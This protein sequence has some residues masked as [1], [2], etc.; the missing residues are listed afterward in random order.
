M[1]S[2]HMCAQL[3]SP[4]KDRTIPRAFRIFQYLYSSFPRFRSKGE[5]KETRIRRDP[6]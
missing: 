5:T 2:A 6:I 4:I 3:V 1:R